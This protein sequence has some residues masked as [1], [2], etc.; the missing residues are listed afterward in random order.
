MLLNETDPSKALPHKLRETV[1]AIRKFGSRSAHPIDDKTTLQVI[2]VEPHEAEWCVEIGLS[3]SHVK[4]ARVSAVHPDARHRSSSQPF[5]RSMS[6]RSMATTCARFHYRCAK[7]TWHGCWR[8]GWMGS[9]SSRSK[10]VWGRP[11]SGAA[12]KFGLEG[13]VSKRRDS[14]YRSGRSPSWVKVKNRS[15]PAIQRFKDAFA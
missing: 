5:T 8:G 11:V 6:R 2:D 9:S 3:N 13:L 10:W 7:Q 15:H 1:D 4:Y 12:C 14:V